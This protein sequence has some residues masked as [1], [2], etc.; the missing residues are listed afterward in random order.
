[1]LQAEKIARKQTAKAFYTY[2]LT[3]LAMV[4]EKQG[5]WERALLIRHK[6][7]RLA[8]IDMYR[9]DSHIAIG[10]NLF[11]LGRFLEARNQFQQIQQDFPDP[12]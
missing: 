3:G 7:I 9:Y 1:M 6:V 12:V 11:F 10:R 2:A 4:R 5:E 8:Q